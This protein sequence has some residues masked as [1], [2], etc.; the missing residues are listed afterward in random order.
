MSFIMENIVLINKREINDK[1]VTRCFDDLMSTSCHV[2]L[3]ACVAVYEKALVA[4][5]VAV[6]QKVLFVGG[7]AFLPERNVSVS[8]SC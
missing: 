8:Y 6:Y 3:S 5:Y 2:D 1:R 7:V 4:C